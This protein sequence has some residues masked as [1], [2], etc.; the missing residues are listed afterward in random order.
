MEQLERFFYEGKPFLCLALGVYAIASPEPNRFVLACAL[1]LLFASTFILRNRFK[2]RRGTPLEELWYEAQ[3][4]LY[5]GVAGYV[6]LFQRSSKI[7]VGCALLLLF[8]G[9]MI[10]RWRFKN[11]GG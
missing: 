4:F 6:F 10:L 8:C 9:M 2:N 3:P 5:L 7:A 1:I 11:R